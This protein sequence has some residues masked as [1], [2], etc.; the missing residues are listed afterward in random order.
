MR[1]WISEITAALGAGCCLLSSCGGAVEPPVTPRA[2]PTP[3]SVSKESPGGDADDPDK[4]ALMRL[5]SEPFGAQTDKFGTIRSAFPDFANWRRVRFVGYPTR[6]GFRYGD[7]HY[8]IAAILYGPAQPDET[9]AGCLERFVNKAR[10]LGKTFNLEL[11]PVAREEGVCHPRLS[12]LD[13]KPKPPNA[14]ARARP[15]QKP[16]AR[17]MPA[18]RTE[19]SFV[20]LTASGHWFAAAVAYPTWPGSCLVQGFAVDG[21]E[22]PD[23][24]EAVVARWL[25]EGAGRLLWERALWEAPPFEDR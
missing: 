2:T 3:T 15:G 8:A 21:A 24:A 11:G 6:A 23:L 13:P 4:A 25:R 10:A 22:H 12:V 7:Q 14:S 9:P 5:L 1:V 16:A 18:I 20:S 19:A 17:P